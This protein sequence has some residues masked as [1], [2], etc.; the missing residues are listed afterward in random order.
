MGVAAFNTFTV[1]MRRVQSICNNFFFFLISQNYSLFVHHC[2]CIHIPCYLV[3]RSRWYESILDFRCAVVLSLC[4]VTVVDLGN[5]T[6][7]YVVCVHVIRKMWLKWTELISIAIKF[8]MEKGIKKL[9]QYLRWPVCF[10]RYQLVYE[11]YICWIKVY[12]SWQDFVS[13]C[14]NVCWFDFIASI[15]G[16]SHYMVM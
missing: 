16:N 1:L 15:Y 14:I 6:T 8:P 3:Y 7:C 5:R 13:F 10:I 11:M 9:P 4:G 12:F 2:D